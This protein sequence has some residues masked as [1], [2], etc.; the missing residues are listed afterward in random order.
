MT[1]DERA[2]RNLVAAWMEA[3]RAGDLDA[4]LGLM[5]D[6]VVFMVPGR[7]PFGKEA[8]AALSRGMGGVRMEGAA[9]IREFAVLGDWA[10]IRNH[11][12]MTI[13]PPGGAPTRRAGYT[14]TLLRKEPDRRWVLARD[15]N[16]VT[17]VGDQHFLG[18]WKPHGPPTC[19]PRAPSSLPPRQA[20]AG[21]RPPLPL[22]GR[23]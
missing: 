10:Y 22:A 14:L 9:D 5:A 6:D 2:I 20:L 11:I 19:T 21:A 7:E 1:D 16:L 23:G 17:E 4:V 12:D 8:F 13:T 15:A 3:S 18:P